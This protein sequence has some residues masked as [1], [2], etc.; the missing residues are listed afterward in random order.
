MAVGDWS[1]DATCI[2]PSHHAITFHES[3]AHDLS[4]VVRQAMIDEFDL[5]QDGEINEQEFF[6]IMTDDA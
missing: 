1:N 4:F 5:D 2:I 3:H 6:A